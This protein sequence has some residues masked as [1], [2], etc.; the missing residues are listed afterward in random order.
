MPI[1]QRSVIEKMGQELMYKELSVE[2]CNEI[3]QKWII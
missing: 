3:L 1:P 2:N